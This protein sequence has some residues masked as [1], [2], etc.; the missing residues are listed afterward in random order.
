MNKLN[1]AILGLT[2]IA[3]SAFA[4][5]PQATDTT[6]APATTSAPAKTKTAKVKKTKKT[7]KPAP[8]AASDTAATAK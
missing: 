5:A 4:A 2:L 7:T 6:M 8:A 1:A 3:G